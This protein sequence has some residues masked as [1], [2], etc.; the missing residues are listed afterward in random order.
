MSNPEIRIY[1]DLAE[2]SGAAAELFAQAASAR[3]AEAGSFFAALS[4]G[5]TPRQLYEL[6]STSPFS[7]R[8]SWDRVHL[9][10]VDE[11]CV[12]PAHPESNFKMI[13]EA[14]LAVVPVPRSCFHRMA[15]E[16]EDPAE[17]AHQYALELSTTLPA[18][19]GD[20]PRFDL[21]ILGMG[22]DG[23]TASLFPDSPAL[24]VTQLWVCPN[25]P[26]EKGWG[27]I[28]LTFPVLNAA[29]QI[30]FLV[31]GAEKAVTL[32][33][34]LEGPY[35]PRDLPA[36]RIKPLNGRLLWYVDRAAA[37]RLRE[38]PGRDG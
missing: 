18:R 32:A 12:P 1:R 9:F 23:H 36:Q 14:L 21:V 13:R 17:A 19:E 20:V 11:R 4:G 38:A 27:R 30:L 2:L 22:A 3:I 31:A 16:L 8:I 10:Q 25:R 15:G 24:N 34:V 33:R 28:T 26:R 5:T 37:E 7:V 35:Q 6:L 29:K